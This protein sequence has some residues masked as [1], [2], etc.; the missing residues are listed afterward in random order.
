MKTSHM[1]QGHGAGDSR[2]TENFSKDPY[3]AKRHRFYAEPS[4][5]AGL[6]ALAALNKR[7]QREGKTRSE[8]I[9]I[10]AAVLLR[11][12]EWRLRLAGVEFPDLAPFLDDGPRTPTPP[13]PR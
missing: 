3:L 9:V 13:Q 2:A 11:A 6:D 1:P 10:A 5:V 12:E 7:E 4:L 8:L